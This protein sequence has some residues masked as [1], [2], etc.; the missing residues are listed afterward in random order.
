MKKAVQTVE[1]L[2]KDV[3]ENHFKYGTEADIGTQKGTALCC[4]V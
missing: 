3:N 4:L 2:Y 1:V